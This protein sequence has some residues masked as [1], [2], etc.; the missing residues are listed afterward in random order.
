MEY[1]SAN[2]QHE[3]EGRLTLPAKSTLSLLATPATYLHHFVI[4]HDD[5][6]LNVHPTLPASSAPD[7]PIP[8]IKK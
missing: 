5:K 2:H 3:V 8:L 4:E 1:K 7:A 6:A